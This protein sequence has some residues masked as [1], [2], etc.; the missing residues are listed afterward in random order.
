MVRRN[1]IT[2]NAVGKKEELERTVKLHSACWLIRVIMR[3]RGR[4]KI[5]KFPLPD[6]GEAGDQD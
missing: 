2:P 5:T 4:T 1:I 6:E 3:T